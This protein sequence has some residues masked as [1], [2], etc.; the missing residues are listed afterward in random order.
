LVFAFIIVKVL[1]GVERKVGL[2]EE[3]WTQDMIQIRLESPA[4]C[5]YTG[6]VHKSLFTIKK[7][8]NYCLKRISE[9]ICVFKWAYGF[10]TIF[11]K[12]L[13]VMSVV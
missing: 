13:Y 9:V 11:K 6:Q 5:S 4:K 8:K 3:E 7:R 1:Y 2:R 12:G 10:E